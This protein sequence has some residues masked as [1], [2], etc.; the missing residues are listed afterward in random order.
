MSPLSQLNNS[1]LK[2]QKRMR[3][4][5]DKT[6]KRF[7]PNFKKSSPRGQMKKQ[8]FK[9]KN[10]NRYKSTS[11]KSSIILSPSRLSL[12]KFLN[13]PTKKL[14]SLTT[15]KILSQCRKKKFTLQS[16][17]LPSRAVRKNSQAE[18]PESLFTKR[19]FT[20]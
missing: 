13:L 18:L 5:K 4:T 3:S 16:R 8:L 14:L 19:K 2:C 15:K 17:M 11:N 10:K 20:K 12:Q 1:N 9:I 6:W 7:N